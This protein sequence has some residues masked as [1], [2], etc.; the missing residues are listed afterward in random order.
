MTRSPR[1][2][3][4]RPA[5]AQILGGAGGAGGAGAEINL[6]SALEVWPSRE[7]TFPVRTPYRA[8]PTM[9]GT[10]DLYSRTSQ[11][12]TANTALATR[13]G[14]PGASTPRPMQHRTPIAPRS[15]ALRSHVV[16]LSAAR[17]LGKDSWKDGSAVDAPDEVFCAWLK[18]RT[19]SDVHELDT[20][21]QVVVQLLR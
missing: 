19:Q 21:L 5:G 20:Q 12:G 8:P 11:W 15:R 3:I 16:R 18:Q 10:S 7:R 14:K 17:D 4:C 6:R 1:L 13:S 2:Q 9:P